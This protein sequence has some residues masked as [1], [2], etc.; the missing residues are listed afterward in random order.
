MSQRHGSA[1]PN[2]GGY[3]GWR[4]LAHLDPRVAADHWAETRL[5]KSGE[6]PD[7]A[8]NQIHLNR[9]GDHEL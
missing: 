5:V 2:Y 7:M 8:M 9:V 6:V 1:E 4:P 3:I